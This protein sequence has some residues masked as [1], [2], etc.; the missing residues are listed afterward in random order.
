MTSDLVQNIQ[1]VSKM[2]P[3]FRYTPRLKSEILS[4]LELTRT[5]LFV[6]GAHDLFD[7]LEQHSHEKEGLRRSISATISLLKQAQNTIETAEKKISAQNKRIEDLEKQA[8]TDE[9]TGL[10]NA[11]GLFKALKR[12]SARMQRDE[13]RNTLLVIVELENGPALKAHDGGPVHKAALKLVAEILDKEARAMDMAARLDENEFVLMF[14]NTSVEDTL[15]RA[16]HLAKNLNNL[17][18]VSDG[19]ELSMSV[20]IGLRSFGP[21]D[22][23]ESLISANEQDD[24][25]M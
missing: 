15:A 10:H 17:A 4:G 24:G 1:S 7:V 11:R 9:L 25:S 21:N 6:D 16:Q 18:L 23:P 5:Q 2:R 20:S 13:A 19:R 14:P 12:E 22:L 3:A 8:T